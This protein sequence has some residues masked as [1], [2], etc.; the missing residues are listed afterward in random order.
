MN[1]QGCHP[2]GISGK[3][4]GSRRFATVR[5]CTAATSC[6]YAS[7]ASAHTSGSRRSRCAVKRIMLRF[8]AVN[9]HSQLRSGP[10]P[11]CGCN[12]RAV[13]CSYQV[14]WAMISLI[15][16]SPAC[17][18]SVIHAAPTWASTASHWLR[19]A[20]RAARAP[21]FVHLS[22]MPVASFV[23]PTDYWGGRVVTP[24]P[25]ELG[26]LAEQLRRHGNDLLAKT[27]VRRG[28]KFLRFRKHA[29]FSYFVAGDRQVGPVEEDILELAH[30]RP[31]IGHDLVAENGGERDERRGTGG[32][33]RGGFS[34]GRDRHGVRAHVLDLGGGHELGGAE[35]A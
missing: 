29:A 32:A 34:G 20:C 33:L 14:I 26:G 11:A 5:A 9:A 1:C 2:W 30:Q 4:R 3:R 13:C 10:G 23:F 6:P 7:W 25:C 12:T 27:Q 18:G 15:A 28:G 35:E 8:S 21:T 22:L 19:P 31:G 24:C 17:S 16:H